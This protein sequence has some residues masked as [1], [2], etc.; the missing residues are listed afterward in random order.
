M[1]LGFYFDQTR[2]TGC[3]TCIVACKDWHDIDAGPARW[4]RVT[5]IEDGKFPDVFVAYLAIACCH[6]ANP[7]CVP[8][9]PASAISKR[10][11]DGLVVVDRETCLGKDS[12]GGACLEACPYNAPQFGAEK[13]ARMQKCNFCLDRLAEGKKPICVD[14]CPMRALDSG[15]LTE[16]KKKYRGQK[17]SEGFVYSAK[18]KPTIIFKP[19]RRTL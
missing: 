14:A 19:K 4:M 6:C 9:C 3:Y 17:G 16:L 15:P 12:C 13:D 8:A 1:Q 7:L 2:C 10:E 18:A 11:E 5:T